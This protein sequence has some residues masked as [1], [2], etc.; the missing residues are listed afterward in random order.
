[1]RETDYYEILGVS[2]DAPLDEIKRAYR[3][4]A[5]QCHPDR[6]PGVPE[7]AEKFKRAARAYEV[8]GDPEKRGLYDTYG[9]AGLSGAGVRDFSSF[10][11]IFSAFGDIFSGSI[12]DSIFG[13]STSERT[14]RGRSLRVALEVELED[15][16]SGTTKTL[17][18]RR[19][20]RCETCGGTGCQPGKKPVG[21]SYCRGYGQVESR[22]GFFTMRTVCP[23]CNGAGSVI[24]DPCRKC[25]GTG[26]TER[27]TDVEIAIPPGVDSGTRLRLQ[28]QGELG[29]GGRRGDLYCDILVAEHPMF[30]R[31]GTDLICELPIAYSTAALGGTAEVPLLGGDT[32]EVR[33]PAGAQSGEAIRVPGRGLRYPRGGQRGDLLVQ[34]VVE[35]P[36]KLTPR[37][38]ELLR[39]LAEIEGTHASERRRSFLRRIKQY[40][41]SVTR[42]QEEKRR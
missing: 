20:E 39:E 13:A 32:T 33:V 4:L 6:N 23:Q 8:L 2:R 14:G 37:Q 16:A 29:S 21:C 41:Q 25:R 5:F 26:L 30:R 40:V 1:M 27:D 22:Q 3:K 24:E 42:P 38:R 11:D 9:E 12:F 28:G 35:T 19:A 15:V 18:I 10:Q 31:N 34:V 36:K 7:A 17:T